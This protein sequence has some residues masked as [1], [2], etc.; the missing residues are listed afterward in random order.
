M[1]DM[2]DHQ[3]PEKALYKV[4]KI[5]S[6]GQT[7]T[8]QDFDTCLLAYLDPKSVEFYSMSSPS[9]SPLVVKGAA[10]LA[11][12]IANGCQDDLDRS[13]IIATMMRFVRNRQKSFLFDGAKEHVIAAMGDLTV[14][15]LI[16]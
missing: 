9:Q 6:A 2:V 13:R 10:S 4:S 12:E 1:G 3:L 5:V 16:K 14:D 11:V 7:F 15:V 8:M